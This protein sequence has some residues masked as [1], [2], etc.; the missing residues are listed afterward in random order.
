MKIIKRIA[1]RISN[2]SFHVLTMLYSIRYPMKKNKVLF[3]SDVRIEMGGNLEFIYNRLNDNYEKVILFKPY[4]GYHLSFKENLN[5]IY[6][7][8]TS[9]YIILDDFSKSISLLKVRENQEIIQLWH[10]AGAFKKFGYSRLDKEYKKNDPDG[11]MNYTKAFVTSEYIRWCYAEGLGMKKENV[12]AL[13]MPRTDIFFDDEYIQN[14]KSEFYQKYP[15]F[16]NKKIIMFAPTYRGNQLKDA[17]Y[18]FDKLDFDKLYKELSNEYIFILKW[19]PG[20]QNVIHKQNIEL[21]DKD[22]YRGFIYDFSNYRDINDL[23]LITDIL[24]TDYSSVIFDYVLLNKPIIYYTYDLRDYKKD[25]GLYF[26]FDEYVYGE[27]VLD[28]NNLIQA[29][30]KENMVEEKRKLFIHR[31]MEACDGNVTEKIYQNVFID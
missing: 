21:Y 11:H 29:I 1:K 6:H 25:R 7:L 28:M 8:T 4:R 12:L 3:L 20:L 30:K 24:I 27:V 10:G 5:R 17:T 15:E 26:E 14:K 18:D 2:I 16:K 13:G 22:D 19:H 23:L 31:F 9:H